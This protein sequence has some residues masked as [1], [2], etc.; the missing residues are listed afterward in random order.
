MKNT[1]ILILIF[2]TLFLIS[3]V[4]DG[5]KNSNASDASNKGLVRKPTTDLAARLYENF[6]SDPQSQAQKD[7][8]DL[9]DYAVDKGLEVVKTP[10]GLYYVVNQK[11]NG[12]VYQNGQ[13]FKAHYSGYFLDGKVFDSSINR[14]RPLQANVGQMIAAWNEVLVKYPTGTKLTLLVPSQ[15]AYG[16]RG[17]PGF[18][19]PNTPLIFDMEILPLIG[20]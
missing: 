8:N 3:C 19:P 18:V 14:G 17:F 2:A 11:G 5:S 4:N 15:L 9:I 10:S 16:D 7:E 20:D 6:H 13:P 1:L 12:I